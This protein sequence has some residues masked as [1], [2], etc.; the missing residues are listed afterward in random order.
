[1]IEINY[2]DFIVFTLFAMYDSP[3]WPE[4]AEVLAAIEALAP[5]AEIGT[6]LSSFFKAIGFEDE[7]QPLGQTIE[8]GPAFPAPIP[9]IPLCIERSL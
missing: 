3:V 4:F 6:R 8:G 1:M 2:A 5:P 9:T 7:G